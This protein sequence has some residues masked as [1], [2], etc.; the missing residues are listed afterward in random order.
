M[1]AIRPNRNFDNERGKHTSY[2][3]ILKSQMKERFD[4]FK[5]PDQQVRYRS[6]AAK[7]KESYNKWFKQ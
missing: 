6:G 7:N 5:Q 3:D 2:T 4:K 1:S